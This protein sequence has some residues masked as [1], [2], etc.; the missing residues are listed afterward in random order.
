MTRIGCFSLTQDGYFNPTL[1]EQIELLNDFYQNTFDFDSEN[2]QTVKNSIQLIS[3]ADGTLYGKTGTGRIDGQDIS[4]WFIGF[5]E[6][7][8]NTYF[9]ATNIQ[10][11]NEATGSNATEITLSVLSDLNLW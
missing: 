3:S 4:G 9:F 1:I 7:S 11:E 6:S 2:I 5:V 10:S 8:E